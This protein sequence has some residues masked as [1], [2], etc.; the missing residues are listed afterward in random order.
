MPSW[1]RSLVMAATATAW[2][3]AGLAACGGD[4]LPP[5]AAVVPPPSSPAEL[6]P[7]EVFASIT[8]RAER[9]RALFAEATRVLLHP[10]C[11]NCHPAGDTPTQGDFGRLHDPPVLRGPEDRGIVGLYCSSC[12]QD[13]NLALARVPGA[14]KWQL[15][16]RSMV[17][18][19]RTPRELCEQIKDPARN[20]Q[21]S[22]AQVVEH[23]AHDPIVAWGWAPGSD[24]TP[25]P[26]SQE[27]FGALVAAWVRDGAECPYEAR[28]PHG[29][30]GPYQGDT[31]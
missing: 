4:P 30:Y 1:R 26:G 27:R 3:A 7:P 24:R 6:R 9:S 18:A 29:Q 2:A 14:P 5:P 11:I 16:P 23:A 17:W 8:D 28:D 25:A 21:R 20:G 10:R 19:G 22:L 12:H 13:R 31:R 15:A